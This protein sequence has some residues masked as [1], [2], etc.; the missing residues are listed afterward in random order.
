MKKVLSSIVMDY[1]QIPSIGAKVISSTIN[2]TVRL[3]KEN[4]RLVVV[5]STVGH[6]STSDGRGISCYVNREEVKVKMD[7]ATY[8]YLY[9][10]WE[11]F[12]KG[13][14]RRPEI[15][16]PQYYP[17]VSFEV[18]TSADGIVHLRLKYMVKD[19]SSEEHMKELTER[20]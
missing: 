8:D 5:G 12:K 9:K 15:E 18:P 4:S 7:Q 14:F 1:R 10:I 13:E 11:R 2:L 6:I 17:E 16:N 20:L 3:N 19:Y